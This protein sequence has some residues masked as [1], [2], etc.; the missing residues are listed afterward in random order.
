MTTCSLKRGP[1]YTAKAHIEIRTR[2][3]PITPR[4]RGFNQLTRIIE[5]PPL[6]Y[7][8][9]DYSPNFPSCILDLF[10]NPVGRLEYIEL[11]GKI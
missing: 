10:E 4:S 3:K 2:A 1:E 7:F 5:K 11:L 9:Y 8:I 6:L